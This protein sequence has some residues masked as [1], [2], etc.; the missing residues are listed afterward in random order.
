MSPTL[1]RLLK[2]TQLLTDL[3]AL[4]LATWPLH[5]W[6]WSHHK[7]LATAIALGLYRLAVSLSHYSI[8]RPFWDELRDLLGTVIYMASLHASL[9]TLLDRDLDVTHFTQGW[10][11]AAI[12]LPLARNGMRRLLRK[13]KLW[14]QPMII[15]GNGPNARDAL[16][17]LKQESAIGYCYCATVEPD[18][19]GRW[20]DAHPYAMVVVA[21]DPEQ[22]A[23]L[24]V[25]LRQLIARSR[26]YFVVPAI[27][28][29]PLEGM[30][31]FHTF[32]HE[33]ML[34]R[35][36]NHLKQLPSQLMKRLFD[37][38]GASLLLVLSS[39]VM[40]CLLLRLKLEGGPLLFWHERVGRNGKSFLCPKLR[41]MTVDADQRL[42]A[43]LNS[44][45]Q[46]RA[47]WAHSQK[48]KNDPRITPL[49]RFLRETS[50]DELPQLWSVLRGDMSLV[51][52][53]PV[54]RAEL[55]RYEDQVSYYMQVLPG[56]TGLWQVSGRSEA[57]YSTR[58]AL[59]VWYVKN[60]SLWTDVVILLKT[61][62]VVVRRKGVY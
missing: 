21:L 8:R 58:V 53:R 30:T 46:S 33:V 47:E 36:S 34:L 27:R 4:V 5:H 55:Q 23:L 18:I 54:T 15:V 22:N 49:G 10:V 52:P 24:Q 35:A 60:W 12:M 37:Y 7:L 41:S 39:P 31:S 51:G 29:L 6:L 56:I 13:L 16:I 17:A 32:S 40:L 48:L 57:D 25:T 43:L 3:A 9:I 28:G 38:V 14:E 62:S 61:A 2:S 11:L 44:C 19:E 50:L 59:D 26:D 45:E 1:Q 20:L 42:E